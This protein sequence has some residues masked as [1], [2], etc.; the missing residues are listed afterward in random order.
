MIHPIAAN[1]AQMEKM[2]GYADIDL[3]TA[4]ENAYLRRA[5]LRASKAEDIEENVTAELT[6]D[7]TKALAGR[8]E[9]VPSW[10]IQTSGIPKEKLSRTFDAVMES[11]DFQEVG[12]HLLNVLAK[13]EC[14]LVKSLKAEIV[15]AYLAQNVDDIV[16]ARLAA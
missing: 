13:S 10:E 12:G 1:A 6:H 3:V 11:L 14:H 9:F 16:A 7:I 8:Q 4:A 2:M 15:R 5:E